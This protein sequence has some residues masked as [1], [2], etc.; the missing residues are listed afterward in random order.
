MIEIGPKYHPRFSD[1]RFSVL[2]RGEEREEI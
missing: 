2:I 1:P